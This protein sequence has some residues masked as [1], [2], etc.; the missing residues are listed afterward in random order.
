[1]S[2]SRLTIPQTAH[3]SLKRF[4]CQ[5][6]RFVAVLDSPIE[7]EVS[8]A[9]PPARHRILIW[10]ALVVVLVA[11]I[12]GWRWRARTISRTRIDS[13]AVL[14]VVNATGDPANEYITDGATDTLIRQLSGIPNL[15]VM[16]R[17][18]VFRFKGKEKD[19][20]SIARML[21]VNSVVT[22]ELR[23]EHD[24][25]VMNVELSDVSEGTVIFSRQYL[26]DVTNLMPVQA[27]LLKDVLTALHVDPRSHG[28]DQHLTTSPAAYQLFLRG[29][30]S[31]Q[32]Q[33]EENLQKAI[34][35]FSKRYL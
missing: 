35:Y 8:P 11:G 22:A 31:A 15:K 33:S 25:L 4:P 1:M 18:A 3:V 24:R 29:E 13:I 26:P 6:Y 10:A 28:A 30:Y 34:E 2:G 9:A 19:A 21:G 17:A 27:D 14:P 5:G 7:R 20:Q 12:S 16:A 32:R 23:Q